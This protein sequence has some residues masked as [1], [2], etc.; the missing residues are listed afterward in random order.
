MA[1]PDKRPTP[2]RGMPAIR[3]ALGDIN[4]A[5]EDV[6]DEDAK[7]RFVVTE[8]VYLQEQNMVQLAALEQS[9]VDHAN[10]IAQHG[11]SIERQE[12]E[13]KRNARAMAGLRRAFAQSVV[14]MRRIEKGQKQ[15]Y[16][17]INS[18]KTMRTVA[19]AV[20]AATLITNFFAWLL[21]HQ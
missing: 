15:I 9:R 17:A 6:K 11:V 7:L 14:R 4:S 5:A 16:A 3:V 1:E 19:L 10:A 21:R 20:T 13:Q 12:A 8:L 2:S 18:P